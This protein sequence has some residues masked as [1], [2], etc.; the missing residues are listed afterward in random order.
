MKSISGSISYEYIEAGVQFGTFIGLIIST[1]KKKGGLKMKGLTKILLSFAL[2]LFLVVPAFATPFLDFRDGDASGGLVTVSGGSITGTNIALDTLSVS[3]TPSMDGTYDLIGA[4]AAPGDPDDG[5]AASLNF[6]WN[7]STGT[8]TIVGGLNGVASV[9]DG[10]LLLDGTFGTLNIVVQTAFQILL[11]GS[12]Y[13]TKDP[14]LLRYMG[15]EPTGFTFL[16]TEIG[17]NSQGGGSPYVADST[18]VNNLG[19]V[20]EPISLILLGSGLAGAGLYRR[21]RKPKG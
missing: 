16:N 13:D 4:L 21:L 6:T 3:G 12:G 10:T 19:K 9:P 7:G 15:I 5:T 11:T 14:G 1:T 8:I 17:A 20:P 18:D 2:S